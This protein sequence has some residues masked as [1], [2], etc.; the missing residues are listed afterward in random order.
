MNADL[1]RQLDE[2]GPEYRD[3]VVRMRGAFE[4]VRR[5]HRAAW[6]V[7]ASLVLVVGLTVV[8]T[9]CPQP[10]AHTPQPSTLFTVRVTDPHNEYMLATLR[11]DVAVKEMIRSQRA[12]GSWKNDFLTRRNAEALRGNRSP[13]AQVAYKKAMRSLRLRGK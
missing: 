13:E 11:N 3:L 1:S 2:M 10:S 6:L 9:T 4:P 7:A 8:L 12:D 5:S